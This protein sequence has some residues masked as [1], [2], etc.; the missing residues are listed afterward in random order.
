MEVIQPTAQIFADNEKMILQIAEEIPSNTLQETLVYLPDLFVSFCSRAPKINPYHAEV[1]AESDAWF[2]KSVTSIATPVY[3]L[4]DFEEI[5]AQTDQFSSLYSMSTEKELSK[6]TK[7]DFALFAA[8]WTGDA[9]KSEFRTICDWCN[10]VSSFILRLF[11]TFKMS[12]LIL[13]N[14]FM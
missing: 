9:G 11:L 6:L 2:A 8:W 13:I 14:S 10:W 1:K 12:N 5:V 7:A 3:L 4:L